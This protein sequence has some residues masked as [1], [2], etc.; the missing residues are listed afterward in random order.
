[1]NQQKEQARTLWLVQHGQTTWSSM[2]W[3]EGHVN[4]ARF[5]RLGKREIRGAANLLA[6]E[7]Q[8]VAVYSSDLLRARRTAMVIARRLR[9]ELRIDP[10]LRERN[11]GIAQGVP[12]ADVPAAATGVT[13]E[14]VIDETARPPGGESLRD[15]YLRCL[16]FLSEL[17]HRSEDGDIVVVAHDASIRMLKAITG[18]DDLVGLA[19][20]T[21]PQARVQPV[22]LDRQLQLH[23]AS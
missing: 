7:E 13:G 12:W 9:R 6:G 8:V 10:R 2:G 3:V 20:T 22:T 5:T 15:V 1:M 11:F 17:A 16:A 4:D 14:L 19:W 21:S 23:A 18:G